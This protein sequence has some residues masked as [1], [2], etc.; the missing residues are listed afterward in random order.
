MPTYPERIV[1]R[2]KVLAESTLMPIGT[3]VRAMKS[4]YRQYGIDVFVQP[5]EYLT[6]SALRDPN[7]G[8]CSRAALT[9]DQLAL[10]AHRND[11]EPNEIAVYF[12]RLA[13]YPGVSGPIAGCAAHPP[14]KPSAIVSTIATEWTLA[15]EIGHVLGLQ[16]V[17]DN[18]RLMTGN[19]TLSIPH[20]PPPPRLTTN[21]LATIRASG[22]LVPT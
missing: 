8:T 11:V 10:F 1:L 7:V 22:L 14:G 5:R 16:H 6:L 19:G 18:T 12:V 20:P 13:I 3:M 2:P 15:H 17:N 21:E 9:S 4:V